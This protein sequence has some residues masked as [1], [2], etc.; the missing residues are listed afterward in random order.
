M[1]RGERE[2]CK[3]HHQKRPLQPITLPI[4]QKIPHHHNPQHHQH[5]HEDLEIEIHRFPQNPAHDDDEGPVEEGRLDGRAEA[6]EESDVD[7][8]VV[9]FVDGGE[10]F[11]GF[12]DEGE[13]DEAEELV[14]DAGV[15][16]GFDL[17]GQVDEEEGG[18][19]EGDG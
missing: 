5:N 15:D 4:P 6:M 9:G 3:T 8:A 12:F 7:D 1:E 14:G 11:G 10:V 13:E 18:E 16:D 19:G 2:D 17:F